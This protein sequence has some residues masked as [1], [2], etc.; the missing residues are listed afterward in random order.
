MLKEREKTKGHFM[1]IDTSNEAAREIGTDLLLATWEA[2]AANS[3]K[4]FCVDD[5]LISASRK[6]VVDIVNKVANLGRQIETLKQV[7][8]AEFN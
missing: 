6:L 8:L 3:S 4:V 7:Y 5:V 1:P 2:F